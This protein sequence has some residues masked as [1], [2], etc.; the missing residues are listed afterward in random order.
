MEEKIIS[1]RECIF[2]LF[3]FVRPFIRDKHISVN[4]DAYPRERES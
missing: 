1:K 3:S 4:I 2:H